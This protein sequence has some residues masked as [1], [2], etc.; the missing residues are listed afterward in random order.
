MRSDQTT[1]S[2]PAARIQAAILLLVASG[3]GGVGLLFKGFSARNPY[4]FEDLVLATI[5]L[6]GAILGALFIFVCLR[7]TALK[8]VSDAHH[9]CSI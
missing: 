9:Q 1:T 2:C 5:L 3:G 4:A 8:R 7:R 6:T